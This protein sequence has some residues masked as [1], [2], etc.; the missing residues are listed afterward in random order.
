[1]PTK[2]GVLM[3]TSTARGLIRYSLELWHDELNK[4]RIIR[5]ESPSI[6]NMMATLQAQEWEERWTVVAAKMQS[7]AIKRAQAECKIFAAQRTQDALDELAS[8]SGILKATLSVDDALDWDRLKDTTPYSEM[9]PIPPKIPTEPKLEELP[10]EPKRQDGQYTPQLSFFDKLISSRKAKI[11]GA[12]DE[13]YGADYRGW[14]AR[15]DVIQRSHT[16]AMQK[17]AE[18]ISA[19]KQDY[20]K[21]LD[22]WKARRDKY[23]AEKAE[24]HAAVDTRKA[25]YEAGDPQ[26]IIEYCELV[27]SASDYPEWFPQEF[28]L[29]YDLGSKILIVDYQMPSP[30]DLPRLKG[31][32]YVASRDEYEDQFISDAQVAKLYDELLY[33]VTL[34]TVHELFEADVIAALD[35]VVINGIVTAIDR[36]TG[37]SV[38]SCLLS[39]RASKDEFMAINLEQVDPKACFK[40]LKGVGSSKLHGLAP[41]APIMQ[42]SREDKRFV[43]S[44]D[45]TTQLDEGVNLASMSWED[46]EHLIRE[47]FQSE[48]S[49][50]GGEVKVT[51]AS[52]DGGVDAVAF[53]PDPIRGGKIVIQAKRYTNTVGV[54]AV[55]DLYGTV[56]NEGANKG[57]LVTTSDFGPDSYAFANG[58]PLVLL[59]G[60]NL[61]HMLQKHGHKARIDLKEAKLAAAKL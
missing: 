37:Q 31:V 58:K 3:P 14:Q 30:D 38:T 5:G 13:K 56:M 52:R 39:L 48:F 40:S 29:D 26:A 50:S 16:L 61:L 7:Q 53:D 8:L 18:L 34:R 23:M 55:R 51:Q 59:N 17:H 42:V 20:R 43:T 47:L 21:R 11:T 24:E 12:M 49:V 28:E 32:K 45:V 19:L 33:Q 36:A 35:V 15:I 4:H 25:A 9:A 41:I 6:V 22:A 54:G 57:I 1:M 2:F 27:L 10:R 60:S 46:F 44:Y